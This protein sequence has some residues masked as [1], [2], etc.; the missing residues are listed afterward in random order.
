MRVVLFGVD[1]ALAE[2]L[3]RSGVEVEQGPPA[4]TGDPGATAALAGGLRAAEEALAGS[5][6]DAV[7]VG[8]D[9]DEALATALTA[10]KLEIP[11]AWLRPAASSADA[12]V[13][14]VADVSL[15]ATADAEA[16][17]AALAELASP[18]I[19]AR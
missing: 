10:V 18:R 8:G 11:T 17:A 16:V 3:A 7:L 4:P 12:L 5:P 13:G 2:S 14:R 15:D 1:A 19:P 9:D 6:P